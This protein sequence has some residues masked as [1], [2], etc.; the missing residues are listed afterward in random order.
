M[1]SKEEI[2]KAHG[3]D[4]EAFALQNKNLAN[5]IL[6]AMEEYS[7]ENCFHYFEFFSKPL[8]HLKPLEVIYRKEHPDP[9]GRFYTPDATSFYKWIVGK[10]L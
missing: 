8:E 1:K 9:D 5:A 10:I 6:S 3:F 4:I 2:L 7:E